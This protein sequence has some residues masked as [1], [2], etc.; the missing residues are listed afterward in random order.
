[1]SRIARASSSIADLK[2]VQFSVARKWRQES[3]AK[4]GGERRSVIAIGWNL[5]QGRLS[6]GPWHSFSFELSQ[7]FAPVSLTRVLRGFIRSFVKESLE[8]V[9][10]PSRRF[11]QRSFVVGLTVGRP[12]R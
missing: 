5:L 12:E 7:K 3:F 10:I 4:R 6:V 1:M 9:E 8:S 2:R 11:Q